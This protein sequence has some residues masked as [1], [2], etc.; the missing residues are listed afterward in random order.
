L[1]ERAESREQMSPIGA[2][3]MLHMYNS[4]VTIFWISP[5][6]STTSKYKRERQE[7][8]RLYY[9]KVTRGINGTRTPKTNT[10]RPRRGNMLFYEQKN[11][12]PPRE[13]INTP[14]HHHRSGLMSSSLMTR[15]KPDPDRSRF[16]R[17]PL[18]IGFKVEVGSIL[19][20]M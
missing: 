3:K 19:G 4:F 17:E 13:V 16:L 5:V 7:E 18:G 11:A 14:N 15:R 6:H 10:R 2:T 9:S 12:S 1:R 8:K 20:G